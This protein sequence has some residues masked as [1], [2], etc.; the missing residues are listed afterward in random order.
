MA[1][2]YVFIIIFMCSHFFTVV[3]D[4]THRK[5]DPPRKARR[6][7]APRYRPLSV[8]PVFI[9]RGRGIRYD[10]LV[11]WKYLY[12][13]D[14]RSDHVINGRS[15]RNCFGHIYMSDLCIYGRYSVDSYF[16][17]IVLTTAYRKL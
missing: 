7:K 9:Y 5:R 4:A 13:G 1:V 3:R 12:H 6:S 8:H 14:Y 15:Y 17:S 2:I 11:R 16:L 10:M